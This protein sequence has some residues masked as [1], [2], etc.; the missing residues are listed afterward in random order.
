[1]AR[2]LSLCRASR[3]AESWTDVRALSG[4]KKI[5]KC[6]LYYIILYYKVFTIK[7]PCLRNVSTLY[8]TFSGSVRQYLYETW[9]VNY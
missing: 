2:R 8:G 4:F 5:P 9:I 3:I 1:M 6:A 7:L